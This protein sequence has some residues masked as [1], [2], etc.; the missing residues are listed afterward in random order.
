M[1]G[2][3]VGSGNVLT[4]AGRAYTWCRGI[5][6]GDG[7]GRLFPVV[8]V[9][10]GGEVELGSLGIVIGWDMVAMV[11]VSAIL[12]SVHVGLGDSVLV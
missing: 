7:G 4:G 11:V 8:G 12:S 2:K 1:L 10:V 3:N 9:L 5:L 6:G